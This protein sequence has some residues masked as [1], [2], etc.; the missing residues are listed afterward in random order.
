MVELAVDK[1]V[2]TPF[3]AVV[4]QHRLKRALQ[5]AAVHD[6]VDGVLAVG[7]RGTAK[8][9]L[10]RGLADLLPRQEVVAGCP[11]GCDPRAPSPRCSHCTDLSDPDVDTRRPPVVTLPLG[12]TR[13]RVVGSLS[14]ADALEGEPSFEPG[15]LARANRGYLYVDEVNLLDDHLVDTLLDAAAAGVNH[16]ERDG[17]SHSHPAEFTLV[18]SMNPEEGELR[19]Q[20]RDRFALQAEVTA[21]T[22]V[23]DR[24]EVLDRA[25]TRDEDED[26][27]RRRHEHEVQD[28]RTTLQEARERD[29]DL[30]EEHRRKIAEVCVDAGVEGHRADIAAARAASALAALDG[31]TKTAESDVREALE[32]ALPHRT[33]GSPFE[34]AG[35]HEEAIKRHLEAGG[36]EDEGDGGEEA[37]EGDGAGE[38]SGSEGEGEEGAGG[39]SPG[40]GQEGGDGD[41]GGDAEPADGERSS[42]SYRDQDEREEAGGS[43]PATASSGDASGSSRSE[44]ESD[45]DDGDPAGDGE[46]EEAVPLQ[47][48]AAVEPEAA[49]EA[50][51]VDCFEAASGSE[52]AAG[53][54]YVEAVDCDGPRLRTRPLDGGRVDVAASV[55]EAARRGST[56]P[57]EDELRESVRRTPAESLTVFAVDA[58]AS[59]AP[60]MERAKSVVLEML[61]ESY[62]GRDEVAFV[63]FGGDDAELLLPPTRSVSTASRHLK[64]LPS[65]GRTPLPMGLELAADVVEREAVDSSLAVVV[66]DGRTNSDVDSPTEATRTSARQLS[67]SDADVLVVDASDGRGGLVDVV[68]EE[69]A[70]RRLSLDELTPDA[71]AAVDS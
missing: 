49:A 48:G 35:D 11:Y 27:L 57:G 32:L 38:G 31:R 23:D 33:R 61:R 53:R 34:E 56:E 25:L 1:K 4:G 66:T 43:S 42:T 39:T 3:P 16:V 13:D 71:V 26:T 21:S 12:A 40:E 41:D 51:D 6:G 52:P 15:L 20:L 10:V 65:S 50:P 58:S 68:V 44:G 29:V 67:A 5:A 22:D 19:P 69:T 37:D 63:A 30:P 14:V 9:T 70:G 60:A 18:G 8:S 55:R 59:M 36:D 64:Q 7:E 62:S 24:V 28:L 17:V 45:A 54:G 2:S 47:P 46:D